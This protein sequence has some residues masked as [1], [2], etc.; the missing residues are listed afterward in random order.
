MIWLERAQLGGAMRSFWKDLRYGARR[1]I[2]KPAF[3]L[4]AMLTLGLGI[5]ANTAI[6]S[7]A[8]ALLLR[9][10]DF[11]DLDRLVTVSGTM[12]QQG[13][14]T[15]SISPA[16]FAD[17]R[18][19]QTVFA[20]LAAYR[21]SN[22]NLTGAAEPER[23]QNFEVSAGFFRLLGGEAALGRTFLPEEEQVASPKWSCWSWSLATTL[24]LGPPDRWR[25]DFA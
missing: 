17:L 5:G 9:P 16:D 4:T 11:D 10:F 18:R 21:Q 6:F 24:W 20:D 23:V 8:N 1:L 2:K 14:G 12:P 3:T 15:Y 19:Q 13:D 22:S 25:D 7:V